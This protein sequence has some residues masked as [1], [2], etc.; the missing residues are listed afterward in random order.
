MLYNDDP[1]SGPNVLDWIKDKHLP[2][3][4][5]LEGHN[6]RRISSMGKSLLIGVFHPGDNSNDSSSQKIYDETTETFIQELRH[7]AQ[8]GPDEITK[9]YKFTQM[10]FV[11]TQQLRI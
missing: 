3:V 6:F 8:Y 2:L 7:F 9:M 1:L 10:N 4:A 5:N 11:A